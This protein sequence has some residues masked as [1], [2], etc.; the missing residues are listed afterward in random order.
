MARRTRIRPAVLR[1]YYGVTYGRGAFAA[2][3]SPLAFREATFDEYYALRRLEYPNITQ[4]RAATLAQTRPDFRKL[5]PKLPGNEMRVDPEPW[6]GIFIVSRARADLRKTG[7]LPR[8]AHALTINRVKTV[9]GWD[10]LRAIRGLRKLQVSLCGVSRVM[11]APRVELDEVVVHDVKQPCLETVLRS[12]AARILTIYACDGTLDLTNVTEHEQLRQLSVGSSRNA[13]A[14]ANLPLEKLVLRSELD[15][16]LRRTLEACA[17]RSFELH[18]SR[19]VGPT[20]LPDLSKLETLRIS[21]RPEHRDAWI[22]WAIAHPLVRCDFVQPP[23]R[24]PREP[25]ISVAA[26]H[27]GV[28]ILAIAKGK[29]VD[30]EVSGDLADEFDYR[31]S[32]GDLEDDVAPLARAAK[33]KV[34]W[35]SEA[36]TFVARAKD[37]DT[38]RWVIDRVAEA[39][40]R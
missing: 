2:A 38:C 11:D 28:D 30:Y 3:S 37:L 25:S 35:S 32:N 15:A 16:G 19:P 31:D 26:I 29:T 9:V 23:V 1:A 34:R 8:G 7:P 36:G 33:K 6:K 14:L 4:Q 39:S 12:T 17:L 40:K 24:G 5:A 21:A 10:G 22:E 27:R 20:E 18:C 13:G